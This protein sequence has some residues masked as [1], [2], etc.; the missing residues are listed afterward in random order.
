MIEE[1]I[2]SP[3][4]LREGFIAAERKLHRPATLR[5]PRLLAVRTEIVEAVMGGGWYARGC[6]CNG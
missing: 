2:Y 1:I 6:A 3:Q 4:G 5:V